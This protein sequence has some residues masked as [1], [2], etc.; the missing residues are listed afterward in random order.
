MTSPLKITPFVE[1]LLTMVHSDKYP[2]I[3]WNDSG[4]GFV[5]SDVGA[6]ERDVCDAKVM[7]GT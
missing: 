5:I 7:I 3:H 6:F 4:D 2:Y 1:H